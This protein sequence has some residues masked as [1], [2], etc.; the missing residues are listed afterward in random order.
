ML[1]VL[2]VVVGILVLVSLLGAALW[3]V[4]SAAIVGLIIGAL[5]R[6]VL[7]GQ[8][9]IGLLATM[10]LGW[11]GSFVGGILGYRVIHAGTLLT[12]LLEIAVAALLIAAYARVSPR[13][14]TGNRRPVRW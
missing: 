2:L 6:L 4:I 8:Q 13:A 9:S 1:V 3:A 11:V 5:A 10:L 12:V 7:P 14:L